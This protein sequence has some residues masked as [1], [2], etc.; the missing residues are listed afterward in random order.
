M[1]KFH[2]KMGVVVLSPIQKNFVFFQKKKKIN[3]LKR[4]KERKKRD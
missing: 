4:K 3:F 2:S 1:I